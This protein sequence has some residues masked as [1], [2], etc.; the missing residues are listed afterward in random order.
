[1]RKLTATIATKIA[2]SKIEENINEHTEA[3]NKQIKVAEGL[4]GFKNVEVQPLVISQ[5]VPMLGSLP[6]YNTVLIVTLKD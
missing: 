4:P 1:M 2:P 6:M 5:A 3:V